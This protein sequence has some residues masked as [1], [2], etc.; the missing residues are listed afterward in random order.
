MAIRNN[1]LNANYMGNIVALK[2]NEDESIAT[3]TSVELNNTS[4]EVL[5]PKVYYFECIDKT[6]GVVVNP[7]MVERENMGYYAI[8]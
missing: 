5:P 7:V 1:I 4:S 2:L 3:L 6:R 8:R